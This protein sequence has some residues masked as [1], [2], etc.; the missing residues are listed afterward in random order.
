MSLGCYCEEVF[1]ISPLDF[2]VS[3]VDGSPGVGRVSAQNIDFII[4]G[5]KKYVKVVIIL[6]RVKI[7]K[8]IIIL[9]VVHLSCSISRWRPV[10]VSNSSVLYSIYNTVEIRQK[11]RFWSSYS[12]Q[13]TPVNI[14][15]GSP[16]NQYML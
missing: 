9:G 1:L 12:I 15:R 6:R 2:L 7:V 11:T 10:V 14:Y 3:L 8:T 4:R 5:T 13:S 16:A